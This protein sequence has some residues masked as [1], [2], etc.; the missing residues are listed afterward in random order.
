MG[1]AK[2]KRGSTNIDMTAMCDVAFLLLSFFILTT[3][4]KPAEAIN[5][6][7]PS[8]VASKAA[9]QKD[10]FMV[11]IDKE[12]RVFIDMSDEMRGDVLDQISA[13]KGL[14][15]TADDKKFFRAATFVGTPL[16]QLTQFI[17]LQP[18]ELGKIKLTGVPTDSSNNELQAWINAAVN[19]YKGRKINFLIKGDN[20]SKYETFK[21]VIAAFKKNE[22]FKYQLITNP[23]GIPS[24]SEL[25]RKN[26]TSAG[27][28]AE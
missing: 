11:S 2:I 21:N 28:P 18:E 9:P 6:S 24:G 23:E 7:P 4:F 5:V 16:N 15:L 25:E 27:E 19:S 1:R 22:I 13:A 10:A 8:S 14:S 3:K 20:D 12:G 26:N 17:R